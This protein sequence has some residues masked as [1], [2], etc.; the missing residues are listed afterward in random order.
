MELFLGVLTII[1]V[2]LRHLATREGI[3]MERR[4]LPYFGAGV[5]VLTGTGAT[6]GPL[7]VPC[8]VNYGLTGTTLLGSE[9]ASTVLVQIAK[10]SVFASIGLLKPEHAPL[11]LLLIAILVSGAAIGKQIA[12]RVSPARFSVFVDIAVLISGIV[13][14]YQGVQALSK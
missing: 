6:I 13:L 9:G 3:K 10:V 1:V 11:G 5:G 12:E 4:H 7:V 14:I 2:P 8:F